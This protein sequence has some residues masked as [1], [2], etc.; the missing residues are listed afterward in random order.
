MTAKIFSRIFPRSHGVPFFLP[1]VWGRDFFSF[2]PKIYGRGK[3][4]S[5]AAI[6]SHWQNQRQLGRSLSHH[7]SR[8]L[9]CFV[10][11]T[12]PM[13]TNGVGAH[14]WCPVVSSQYCS[15][16]RMPSGMSAAEKARSP[17]AALTSGAPGAWHHLQSSVPR[18]SPRMHVSG[19]MGHQ[20]HW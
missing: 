16:C 12:P 4:F 3:K 18:E 7:S 11:K 17:P 13:A 15:V 2:R 5:L 8:P 1:K 19:G 6:N 14:C 9:F 20:Q 10:K